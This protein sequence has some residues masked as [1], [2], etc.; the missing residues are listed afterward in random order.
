MIFSQSSLIVFGRSLHVF[1][2]FVNRHVN[3]LNRYI[4]RTWREAS[5]AQDALRVRAG[6]NNAAVGYYYKLAL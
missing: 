1:F 3:F 5:K 2:S 4:R 6:H